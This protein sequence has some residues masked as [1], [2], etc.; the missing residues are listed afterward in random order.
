MSGSS[1]KKRKHVEIYEHFSRAILAGEHRAGDRLP[2]EHEL[3]EIFG[4]SRPTVARALRELQHA[5]LIERRVG[6]GTFVRDHAGS[7]GARKL[8][9][10]L[11]PELGQTEIFEPICAQV[12]REVQTLGHS[13][14]WG[15]FGGLSEN[16][17]GDAARGSE[18]RAP[19]G[20]QGAIDEVGLA[21]E[22]D[23]GLA[24]RMFRAEEACR[25]FIDQRVAGVF[26]APLEFTQD[27]GRANRE[28]L[29]AFEQ[30]GI[31]VVLL[32]RDIVP[33]PERSHYDLVGIDNVRGSFLLARHLIGLG[34]RR[35]GFIARPRSAPTVDRRI[36]GYR[37]ALWSG[38]IAPESDWARFGDPGD[39][40]FVRNLIDQVRPEAIICANDITAAQL[41]QTLGALGVSVPKDVGV[42]G[43]DD[44]K[45]AQLLGV[46]LTTV[47]Q[48]CQALG[49]IALR[50]LLNRIAQ[51]ELPTCTLM[52]EPSLVVRR[53]CGAA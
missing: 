9:G 31:P 18:T 26:F 23:R 46:P 21:G 7:A 50:T 8:F 52:L 20:K 41:M 6:S 27:D 32:D 34:R 33:F 10:L 42:A 48:P 45:Y 16:H 14:L 4:S 29:G 22:T 37:E 47:R 36:A 19:D 17:R 25:G 44:V 51:P 30:A 53:S 28:I 5:G 11:I 49:T 43:F 13:L 38:G 40:E 15:D 12:A 35:I 2:S 39:R 1:A 3:V 24:S